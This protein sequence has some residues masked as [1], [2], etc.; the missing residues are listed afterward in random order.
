MDTGGGTREQPLDIITTTAGTS[1]SHLWL[2]RYQY[3]VNVVMGI[4]TDESVFVLCYEID[5]E[6]DPLDE[7]CWPKANPNLGVSV[8][9]DYLR[10]KIP[11][12]QSSA[13]KRNEFRRY[14]ANKICNGPRLV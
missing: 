14:H 12:A 9:I 8:N 11:E 13:K 10:Q 1:S 2:E 5:D 3:F 4:V 7:A 6:D